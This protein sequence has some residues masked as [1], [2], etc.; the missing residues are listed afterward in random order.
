MLTTPDFTADFTERPVWAKI[1]LGIAKENMRSIRR[2]VGDDILISAV[3]KANAYGHGA[4][5]LSR[6]FLAG[7]ANRLAVASLDEAIELRQAGL[8]E[9]I[10]ILGHT[11]GRRAHKALTHNIDVCVY[12]FEDAELFSAA[13]VKL[14]KVAHLHIATDTGMGRIGYQPSE[15]SLAEIRRIAALPSVQM[16]GIF[17]QFCVADSLD[18]TFSHT[19]AERFHRFIDNLKKDGITFRLH[20]AANSAAVLTLRDYHLD[21]V[22]PGIIQYGCNPSD[23]V[24]TDGYNLRPVMSLHACISNVKTIAA[25]DTVSY[26]R[27]FTATRPTVIATLPLGYADGYPR[28]LSGRIDVLVHGVRCRQV[29]NVCMDQIMVDVT[30]V[31]GVQVGDEAVLFGTQG[32]ETIRAEEIARAVETIPYEITCNINRRV[33][34]VYV[35]NGKIIKRINYL[36]YK[37]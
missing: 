6:A 9:P 20:H 24:S 35:D 19:Q 33:A 28:L 36:N 14:G 12:R 1:D 2:Q 11:D 22:R 37:P 25:G 8:T 27:N 5:D 18:K 21:M 30:G 26:G 15:E 16:T 31:E 17:T 29:G 32:A 10:L 13:A 34:R 23:E 7:G 4:I 3:V